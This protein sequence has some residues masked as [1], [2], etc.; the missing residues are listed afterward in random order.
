MSPTYMSLLPVA[1]WPW[2]GQWLQAASTTL[3]KHW[4]SFGI[5]LG[6]LAWGAQWSMTKVTGPV[7]RVLDRVPPWSIFKTFHACSFLITLASL[8]KSGVPVFDALKRMEALSGKN[9]WLRSYIQTML[10]NLRKGGRNFGQHLD[11]GLLDKSTALDVIDYS[12]LGRFEE[13]IYKMGEQLLRKSL[14]DIKK[15]MAV[16]KNIMIAFIGLSVGAIYYTSVELNSTVASQASSHQS[17]V[18][19]NR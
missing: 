5:F 2:M 19:N 18:I 12:E 10:L 7:R 8:M 17:R 6:I 1:E 9:I 13:A 3:V 14:V 15:G 4:I 11:V 16:A